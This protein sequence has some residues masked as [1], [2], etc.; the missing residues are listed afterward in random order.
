VGQDAESAFKLASQVRFLTAPIV[1]RVQQILA[2]PGR[3]EVPRLEA[4]INRMI[5]ELYGL[6]AEEIVLVDGRA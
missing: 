3:P 2:D 1:E 6:T 5:Y 4:E